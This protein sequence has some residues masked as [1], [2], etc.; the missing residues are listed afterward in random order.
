MFVFVNRV[1]TDVVQLQQEVQ[2]MEEVN[3]QLFLELVNLHNEKVKV[4][5]TSNVS[6]FCLVAI[7]YSHSDTA[8]IKLL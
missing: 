4:A 3:R 2:A 1:T 7:A 8:F 6:C 5:G